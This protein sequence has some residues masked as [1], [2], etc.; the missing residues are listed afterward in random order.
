MK[1]KGFFSGR[2]GV[3][4]L[5]LL[6]CVG[7]VLLLL[8][9]RSSDEKSTA[10][11]PQQ[12]AVRLEQQLEGLLAS[13]EGV[14]KCRVMVT[15]HNDVEYLYATGHDGI[16]TEIQPTVRGVVVVCDGG[17]QESVCRRVTEAVTTALGITSGR[18]CVEKLT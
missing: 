6:G 11:T 7:V 13:V 16:V 3:G 14:G 10:E 12:Y 5:V 4:A 8:T 9:G 15:V 18:V 2:R 17:A 1:G